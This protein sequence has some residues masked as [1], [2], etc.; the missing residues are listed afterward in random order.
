MAFLTQDFNV[1]HMITYLEV[2]SHININFH[3]IQVQYPQYDLRTLLFV[4]YSLQLLNS[5]FFAM[6]GVG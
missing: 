2:T 4:C 5:L 1:F 6:I 3:D